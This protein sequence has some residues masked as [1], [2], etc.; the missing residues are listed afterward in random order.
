MDNFDPRQM[1][2]EVFKRVRQDFQI[3]I[4]EYLAALKALAGGW[5]NNE[6]DLR[7]T[8]QLLWCHSSSQQEQFYGLWDAVKISLRPIDPN[9]K[10][11]KESKS[12]EKIDSDTQIEA[13]QTTIPP[14]TKPLEW[15][16]TYRLGTAPT[17][18]PF[19]A[20]ETETPT[21]FQT[22]FPL[23]RRAMVYHWQYVNRPVKDGSEDILDVDETVEK[24]ARQ[25][26]FLSPV[27]TRRETN[28]AHL[29][30]LI[31]QNGSMTPFHYLTRELVETVN[32]ESTLEKLDVYYF[33]NVPATSIYRDPYLTKSI[34][35]TQALEMCKSDTSVLIVS[36]G[37]A[38][39][40]FRR[41]ERFEATTQVLA[42]IGQ[43]TNYIAWLNPMPQNR[44]QRT[45]AQLIAYRV[46]MYPMNKQ[47]LS[48][49]IDT[50]MGKKLSQ[51]R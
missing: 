51:H 30:L 22:D 1:L 38:A 16:P 21:A 31:D 25:G 5:G 24:A 42:D 15:Q 35:L 7:E 12:P 19:L 10:P 11:K 44:W 14:E 48:N 20:T 6:E 9:D 23:S 4:S 50:I 26:F 2:D 32:C 27:Y 41:F 49:A 45:S 43:K 29:L 47:G 39:R 3:G 28:H 34:L 40:G 8:L 17:R 46:P 13:T 37:G 36:D 18:A 33:H